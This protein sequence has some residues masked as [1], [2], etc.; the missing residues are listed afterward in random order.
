MA[1]RMTGFHSKPNYLFP[2]HNPIRNSDGVFEF[3]DSELWVNPAN[4]SN[5]PAESKKLMMSTIPREPRRKTTADQ[6]GTTAVTSSS[7]PVNIPDWSKI[8]KEQRQQRDTS[9]EDVNE[10]Y[11]D[12]DADERLPPHEYL[13]RNRG[14]SFSVHEGVGRTLKGRDL[15]RVRNAIWK[16]VGFED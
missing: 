13:A 12:G 11:E 1:S 2:S 6:K 9:D 14:A 10:D 15:R 8:L 4:G 7:V 16:Q 5:H 3:D